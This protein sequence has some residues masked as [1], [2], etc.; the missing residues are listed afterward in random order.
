MSSYNEA[1]PTELESLAGQLFDQYAE[2]CRHKTDE[3]PPTEA[4]QA[5]VT[6]AVFLADERGQKAWAPIL[7]E[8]MDQRLIMTRFA[9]YTPKFRR[10][11]LRVAMYATGLTTRRADTPRA[12]LRLLIDEAVTSEKEF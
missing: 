7:D 3:N 4:R 2:A 9:E 5:A 6:A 1:A 12:A 11:I 8:E 10:T